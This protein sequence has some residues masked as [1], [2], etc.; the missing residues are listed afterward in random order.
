MELNRTSAPQSR[1]VPLH[2]S[3]GEGVVWFVLLL[4]ALSRG[5]RTGFLRLR[6]RYGKA[7]CCSEPRD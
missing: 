5:T 7:S 6:W 4:T 3:V 2:A 1:G